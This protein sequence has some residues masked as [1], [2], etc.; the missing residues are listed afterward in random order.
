MP[1]VIAS[2]FR[3]QMSDK[4]SLVEENIGMMSPIVFEKVRS[5]I[6]RNI[7][8]GESYTDFYNVRVNSKYDLLDP[9]IDR[10]QIE[11][12]L[13]ERFPLD[14]LYSCGMCFETDEENSGIFSKDTMPLLEHLQD[15]HPELFDKNP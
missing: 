5:F 14:V 3:G 15:N 1:E 10:D 9:Q 2:G 4:T 12:E 11:F 6:E 8:R 13:R 7:Q